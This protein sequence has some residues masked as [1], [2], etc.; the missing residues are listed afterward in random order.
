MSVHKGGVENV[1]SDALRA[2]TGT[3]CNA[4]AGVAEATTLAG[5]FQI[6]NAIDYC[7]DGVLY[8]KA[9]E[10]DVAFSSGHAEQAD[11]TTRYYLVQIDAAGTLSTVQGEEDGEIPDPSDDNCPVGAIKV[12]TD[13]GTFTPG[14]TDLSDAAVTDTYYDLAVLPLDRAP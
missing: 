13:G 1:H 3:R 8:A 4:A 6:A 11:G 12:V 5:G 9:A 7:I 14:T 2:L 10:D